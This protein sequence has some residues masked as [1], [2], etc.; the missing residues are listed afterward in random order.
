MRIE[1]V[2]QYGVKFKNGGRS[3]GT[4]LSGII[5]GMALKASI[6]GVTDD[7][8]LG[9]LIA[10]VP[11]VDT[12]THPKLMKLAV[13][14][15]WEDWIYQHIPGL[16]YHPGEFEVDGI[17]MTPD[18]ITYDGTEGRPVLHEFK[19]TYYSSNKPIEEMQMWLWQCAGYLMGLSVYSMTECTEAVIHPLYLKGDYRTAWPVYQPVRLTFD[20]AEIEQM[21]EVFLAHKYLARVEGGQAA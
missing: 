9:E 5:K 17:Y 10:S 15:A 8:D 7:G 16:K 6:E 4:H 20:W 11:L 13:G 14:L 2:K 18:G 3:P 12:G 21:W 19:A 1:R